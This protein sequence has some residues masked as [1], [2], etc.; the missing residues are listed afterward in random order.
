M[1]CLSQNTLLE[2]KIDIFFFFWKAVKMKIFSSF[3]IAFNSEF[4]TFKLFLVF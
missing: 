3:F 4:Y 2:I 1:D